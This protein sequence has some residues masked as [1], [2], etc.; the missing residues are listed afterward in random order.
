[1]GITTWIIIG[2]VIYLV[3]SQA[4]RIYNWYKKVKHQIKQIDRRFERIDKEEKK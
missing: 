3:A 2:L 4:P 1:M